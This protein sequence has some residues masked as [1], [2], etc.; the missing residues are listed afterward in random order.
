ML[1]RQVELLADRWQPSGTYT[2]S[3]D[4]SRLP[5]GVYLLHMQFGEQKAVRKM[6]VT[7]N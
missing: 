2:L 6:I 7:D 5:A 3:F 4:G 1:G